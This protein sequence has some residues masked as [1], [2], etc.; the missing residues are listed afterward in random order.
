MR[1]M[2]W[3]L[4]DERRIKYKENIGIR[5]RVEEKRITRR[6]RIKLGEI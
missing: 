3:E 2:K 6:G 5:R 4:N 1:T